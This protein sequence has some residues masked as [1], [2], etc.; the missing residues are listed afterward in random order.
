MGETMTSPTPAETERMTDHEPWP[1]THEHMEEVALILAR[2]GFHN[3]AAT[4]RSASTK[5]NVPTPHNPPTPAEKTERKCSAH[6]GN[7]NDCGFSLEDCGWPECRKMSVISTPAA[8]QKAMEVAKALNER[9]GMMAY[10]VDVE[11]EIATAL[12]AYRAEGV[13]ETLARIKQAAD[14]FAHMSVN[15]AIAIAT[16]V[17]ARARE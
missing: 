3:A 1:T 7:N 6:K 15:T 9:I 5:L 4:V 16:A 11:R 13:R 14:G 8:G 17:S 10:D 12:E 2:R